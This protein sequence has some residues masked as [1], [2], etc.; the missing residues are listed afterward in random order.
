MPSESETGKIHN[1]PRNDKTKRASSSKK[2]K[3]GRRP[4]SNLHVRQ[5][6]RFALDAVEFGVDIGHVREI[7][8]AAEMT[9][10]STDTTDVIGVIGGPD[11]VIDVVDLGLRLGHQ[12]RPIK[13]TSRIIIF[14]G[15]A[16]VLGVL[17]D[18]VIDVLRLDRTVEDRTGVPG[19]RIEPELIRETLVVDDQKIVVLDWA[20]MLGL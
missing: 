4:A 3:T 8:R 9:V 17:V 19:L 2:R 10:K 5:L 14:Q 11:G 13:S 15:D 16:V 12:P 7:R 20:R 6:V 1:T 18:E